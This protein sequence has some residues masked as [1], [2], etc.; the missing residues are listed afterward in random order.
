MDVDGGAGRRR[1]FGGV[2]AGEEGKG[3]WCGVCVVVCDEGY[4]GCDGDCVIVGGGVWECDGVDV[5][6]VFERGRR[7]RGR[8]RRGGFGGGLFECYCCG[9]GLYGGCGVLYGVFVVVCVCVV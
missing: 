7:R 2:R 1:E 8:F 3:G 6:D 9:V 5:D 4:W